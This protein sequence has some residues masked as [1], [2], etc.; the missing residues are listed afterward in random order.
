MGSVERNNKIA[1]ARTSVTTL[2]RSEYSGLAVGGR[3]RGWDLRAT[4]LYAGAVLAAA[5]TIGSLLWAEPLAD[6]RH[7]VLTMLAC[8]ISGAFFSVGSSHGRLQ[9]ALRAKEDF[10]L[11]MNRIAER[12]QELERI[13]LKTRLSSLTPAQLARSALQGNGEQPPPG[14]GKDGKG[15]KATMSKAK[16]GSA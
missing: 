10:R 2:A 5:G 1:S 16:R 11:E 4:G 8:F 6:P 13:I 9:D 7:F 15:D 14:P 3:W 12:N